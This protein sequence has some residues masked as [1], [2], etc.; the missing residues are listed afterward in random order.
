MLAVAWPGFGG[1]QSGGA[2]QPK[3]DEHGPGNAARFLEPRS[4]M[5][6]RAGAHRSIS[7][8]NESMAVV[9]FGRGDLVATC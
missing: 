7:I 5:R 8:Q 6:S 2:R 3:A 9:L 1:H 4:Q